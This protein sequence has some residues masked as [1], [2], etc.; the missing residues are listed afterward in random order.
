MSPAP[1][2]LVAALVIAPWHAWAPASPAQPDDREALL[3]VL[4]ASLPAAGAVEAVFA[5][6]EG[7]GEQ[8]VGFDFATG[9]WFRASDR[10][11]QGREPDGRHYFGE[12]GLGRTAYAAPDGLAILGIV[13]FLPTVL[14]YVLVH[15]PGLLRMAQ[16]TPAGFEAVL[17]LPEAGGA[18]SSTV[19]VEFTGAGRVVRV[20]K[21][22]AS[23]D[24]RRAISYREDSPEF[25]PLR[26]SIPGTDLRLVS[27]ANL[28]GHD[29]ERFTRERVEAEAAQLR[30][31]ATQASATRG[32]TGAAP[33]SGWEG[34][35]GPPRPHPGPAG[36]WRFPLI[37]AGI[38]FVL[39]GA[40]AIV[41]SRRR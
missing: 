17:Q 34:A 25:M 41:W 14:S 8:R 29:A 7:G 24:R 20:W 39:I 35:G 27:F 36:K 21:D 2:A 30:F 13:D 31:N 10:L 26:T 18:S 19:N 22:G 6:A 23:A 15:D 12:A 40:G 38:V 3:A 5:D 16:R 1:T 32:A 11:A 9:A 28:T 4:R 37:G 33:G